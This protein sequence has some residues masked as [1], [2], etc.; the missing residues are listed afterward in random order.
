MRY[1]GNYRG[2]ELKPFIEKLATNGN[3]DAEEMLGR[4]E[5]LVDIFHVEK[6]TK[7]CCMPLANNP[8]C[9]FHPRLSIFS[10]IA[11]TNTESYEQAF[12]RL[13]RF[14]YETKKMTRNKRN[15]FF[16]EVNDVYNGRIEEKMKL[17]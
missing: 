16:I 3:K 5:F 12:R 14:K 10:E 17:K 8:A 7:S 2:C 13:N 15:F 9:E 1:V 11:E 4:V 6:H